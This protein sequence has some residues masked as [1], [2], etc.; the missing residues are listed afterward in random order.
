MDPEKNQ[1]ARGEADFSAEDAKVRTLLVSTD[2]ELAIAR[3]TL[4]LIGK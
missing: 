4:A 3:D 1:A 2:E